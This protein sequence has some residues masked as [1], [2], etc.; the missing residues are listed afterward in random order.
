MKTRMFAVAFAFLCWLIVVNRAGAQGCQ[1][2][3]YYSNYSSQSFDDS[4]FTFTQTVTTE[5]Y[6][7][8]DLEYCRGANTARHAPYVTNILTASN[9][10][11]YGGTSSGSS[12]C[13][14][15]Y[16]TAQSTVVI[17]GAPG[18][19]YTNDTGGAVSCSLA[20]T[21]WQ[22]GSSVGTRFVQAYFY[23]NQSGGVC[24]VTSGVRVYHRCNPQSGSCDTVYLANSPVT[25][26]GW[27]LFGLFNAIA[28]ENAQ[29]KGVC[30]VGR[31]GVRADKCT[32]PDPHP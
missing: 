24:T 7:S 1:P 16:I 17:V 3:S 11:V 31:H 19:V 18:D 9:G 30:L 10:T 6:A 14:N 4:N 23:C 32:S 12:G 29:G 8:M 26:G 5:G 15:C 28:I 22:V 27:P 2:T 20:G 21:F 13:V 25:D